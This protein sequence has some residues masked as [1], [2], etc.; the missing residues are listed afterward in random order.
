MHVQQRRSEK[1]QLA[2]KRAPLKFSDRIVFSPLILIACLNGD[3][4]S[5]VTTR[6]VAPPQML[7]FFPPTTHTNDIGSLPVREG[8]EPKGNNIYRTSTHVGWALR[9]TWFSLKWLTVRN[10]P[11]EYE[12]S[13][14][15]CVWFQHRFR[16]T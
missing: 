14:T 5:P 15:E 8:F 1:L 9:C 12:G 3:D 2:G 16:R 4:A 7:F 11:A 10:V 6:N 13:Q